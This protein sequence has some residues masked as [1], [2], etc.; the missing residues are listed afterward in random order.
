MDK[1]L[2]DT[3]A[4][5]DIRKATKNLKSVWAQ[6]TIHHLVKYQAQHPRLTV[7]AFT[8]FE[9]LDGLYRQ[10][11]QHEANDFRTR[12]LPTLEVIYADESVYALA[13]EIHAALAVSGEAIGVVDTF[14]AATAIA[15]ELP[16]VNANPKH[17]SRVQTAGF[18]IDLQNWRDA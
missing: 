7:S 8:A 2:I 14:I 11:R 9:Y 6:N 12:I 18:S 16:L 13:A 10:G 4:F 5:F 3:S 1:A 17:F 15:N